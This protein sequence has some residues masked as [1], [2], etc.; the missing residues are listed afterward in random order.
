VSK[1]SSSSKRHKGSSQPGGKKTA[2]A[3]KTAAGRRLPEAWPLALLLVLCAV[4]LNPWAVGASLAGWLDP[5]PGWIPLVVGVIDVLLIVVA[6]AL[7]KTGVRIAK[8]VRILGGIAAAV[9]ALGALYPNAA[10]FGLAPSLAKDLDAK[11]LEMLAAE[12]VILNGTPDLKKL[13]KSARNLEL[14][15]HRSRWLFAD[16]VDLIDLA[17]APSHD[18]HGETLAALDLEVEHWPLAKRSQKVDGKNFHMWQPLIDE[19]DYFENAKFFFVDSDY[20]GAEQK[21]WWTKIGFKGLARL[22][23]GKWCAI[24]ADQDVIWERVAPG[25]TGLENWR[26]REWHLHDLK[27]MVTDRIPFEDVLE[28]VIPDSR[29]L[30]EARVNK[31]EQLLTE[32]L[33]D[34][35]N[36]IEERTFE[37]P[38]RYFRGP[39]Q[40]R[41]PGCV[42]TDIDEDG[43]DDIYVM[44]RWGKNLY[45]RNRGD[46][47][48]EEIAAR[49]GLDYENHSTSAIFADFDNDGDRDLFLG[50]WMERSLYLVNEGGRFVD[51]S[52]EMVDIGLP[53]LVVSLAAADYNGDG[54]LDIYFSTYASDAMRI[55]LESA[56]GPNFGAYQGPLSVPPMLTEFLEFEDYDWLHTMVTSPQFDYQVFRNSHGPPNILLKNVGGGRFSEATEKNMRMFRHTYQASWGDYDSDGDPDLYLAHDFAPNNLMRNEGNGKFTDVTEETKTSDIGYGMAASW[57]DY[58]NDEKLDLYISGMFSKAGRRIMRKVPGVNYDLAIMARGNSL[59]R[60]AE[61]AFERVSGDQEGTLQVEVAGW[62]WGSGFADFDNDGWLDIYATNGHYTAPKVVEAQI[63]L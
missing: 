41:H 18:G 44:G 43:F 5:V 27:T 22:N 23:D 63:D 60:N 40:D 12:E 42:V 28:L 36:P 7:L 34:Y 30:E 20:L 4:L 17:G 54:L 9:V 62:S 15:D 33:L 55:D 61:P 38:N 35:P 8:R 57:G 29:V 51:R 56:T 45:L 10:L 2:P 24:K 52:E 1:R 26:A 50:R 3:A 53:Y 31:H 48:F 14:P 13:G 49:L 46:G 21:I 6:T 19:I 58:D 32:F 16:E 39:A 47:T 59:L 25:G 11:V 37:M